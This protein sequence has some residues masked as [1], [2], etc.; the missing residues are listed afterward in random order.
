[1]SVCVCVCVCCVC[2]C[3]LV[4]VG[5]CWC[6]LVCVGVLVC[7]CVCFF[8]FVFLFFPCLG[9]SSD[10]FSSLCVCMYFMYMY[11]LVWCMWGRC[12]YVYVCENMYVF[13]CLYTSNV[14]KLLIDLQLKFYRNLFENTLNLF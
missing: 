7:W 4:C 9:E 5:V 11:I 2:V 14:S 12:M 6:V 10:M 1:M 8:N 3:V 13:L